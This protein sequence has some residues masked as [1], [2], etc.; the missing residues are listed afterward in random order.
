METADRIVSLQRSANQ[1]ADPLVHTVQESRRYIYTHAG[2]PVQ[3]SPEI[4]RK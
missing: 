2:H 3:A 4:T 1:R